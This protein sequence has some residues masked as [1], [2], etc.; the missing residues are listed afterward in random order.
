MQ[1]LVRFSPDYRSNGTLAST[2]LV[3]LGPTDDSGLMLCYSTKKIRIRNPA[4]DSQL[5][6]LVQKKTKAHAPLLSFS[7]LSF[8]ST[9]FLS[10][11]RIK[12]AEFPIGTSITPLKI[13][14]WRKNQPFPSLY[15]FTRKRHRSY[16]LL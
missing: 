13:K 2:P 16:G 3:L 1:I 15:G 6:F 5:T 4:I 14:T 8:R 11:S 7:L 9:F 10:Q 12:Q